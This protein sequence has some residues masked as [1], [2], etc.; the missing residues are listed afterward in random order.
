MLVL[1]CF[2][3]NYLAS[4]MKLKHKELIL[5]ERIHILEEEETIETE[6][7]ELSSP[8]QQ[9]LFAKKTT[10]EDGKKSMFHHF[11]YINFIVPILRVKSFPFVN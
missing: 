3:H 11:I 7:E 2:T 8:I 6:N 1:L 9:K 5:E 10:G 4:E